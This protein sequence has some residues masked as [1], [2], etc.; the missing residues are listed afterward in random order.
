MKIKKIKKIHIYKFQLEKL[1][2]KNNKKYYA[3]CVYTDRGYSIIDYRF[4]KLLFHTI[5][6]K[7]IVKYW[8]NE[9]LPCKTY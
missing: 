9:I 7:E 3:V 8:K 4:E 6:Y 1:K 5:K 2:D